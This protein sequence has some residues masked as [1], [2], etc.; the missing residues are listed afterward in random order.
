MHKVNDDLHKSRYNFHFLITP[1]F[2]IYNPLDMFDQI[3]VTPSDP[4][5]LVTSIL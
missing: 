1:I 5:V 3:R 2:G 4:V